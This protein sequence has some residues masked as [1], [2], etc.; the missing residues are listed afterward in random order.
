M[1]RN[2]VHSN[3]E[4]IE[5]ACSHPTTPASGDP[6]RLG[7]LTGVALIDE[8]SDGLTVMDIGLRTWNLSVKGVNG[9]GNSAVAAGDTLYYV[10]ADTPPISKKATGHPYGYALEAVGS[11]STGTIKVLHVPNLA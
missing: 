2:L 4:H 9:S 11:G 8:R 6:C 3:P 10:D 1:A 5:V 7:N